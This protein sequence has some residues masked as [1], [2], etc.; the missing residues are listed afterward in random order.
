M[1]IPGAIKKAT[2]KQIS[3][4]PK[5]YHQEKGKAKLKKQAKIKVTSQ[6]PSAKVTKLRAA[7]NKRTPIAT[8]IVPIILVGGLMNL[9]I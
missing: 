4:P 8:K 6:Y 1:K 5:A 3:H 2:T 7:T 9:Y